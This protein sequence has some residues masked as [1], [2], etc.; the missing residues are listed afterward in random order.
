MTVRP[1][2][3]ERPTEAEGP[4]SPEVL[5]KEAR[6][7]RRRRWAVGVALMVGVVS[8]AAGLAVP[9]NG[10]KQPSRS[11]PSSP[12]GATPGTPNK[13]TPKA[14]AAL[15][16]STPRL[17]AVNFFNPTDGYGLFESGAG[18]SCVPGVAPTKDGGGYFAPLV[19]LPGCGASNVAF[20]D[21]GDGFAYGP[22]L[23]VTHDA[24]TTWSAVAQP[25]VV[26]S[27]EALGA[28]VW[29]LEA[30]CAHPATASTPAQTC[31]PSVAQSANGGRTWATR[32]TQPG[33]GSLRVTDGS[34]SASLVRVS[35]TSAYVVGTPGHTTPVNRPSTTT[36]AIP[37]WFTANG[38]RTWTTESIPCGAPN[39]PP[40]VS[41]RLSAA[42]DGTLFAV[43]GYFTQVGGSQDKAV[44]VSSDHGAS[45]SARGRCFEG[46]S[47]TCPARALESG[48]VG[49]LDAVSATTAFEFGQ[50]GGLLETTDGGTTWIGE[51]STGQAPF[52]TGPAALLFFGPAHGVILG[53]TMVWHTSDGTTWRPV[54]P[55]AART[56][57]ASTAPCTASQLQVSRG[58]SA[59]ADGHVLSRVFLTNRGRTCTLSGFPLLSGISPTGTRRALFTARGVWFGTLLP[60]VL[61][62]GEQGQL[63]LQ[64]TTTCGGATHVR[65]NNM[66]VGLPGAG[67][68]LSLGGLSFTLACGISESQLGIP[69]K[70]SA[71]LGSVASL[72]VQLQPRFVSALPGTV[73]SGS[74]L[75]Y[76]VTLYNLTRVTVRMVPC[77]RYTVIFRTGTATSKHEHVLARYSAA[78]ACRTVGSIP[79][80]G[81]AKVSLSVR[82]PDVSPIT[83]GLLWKFDVPGVVTRPKS[84]STTGVAES[85][86]KIFTA[87]MAAQHGGK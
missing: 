24:G 85:G 16:S 30:I 9:G 38:G 75:H 53:L 2:L 15:A 23:Y 5:F 11:S 69:P 26:L 59:R 14:S 47:A 45:W 33:P 83:A 54:I 80:G 76:T 78:F 51:T 50:R 4:T 64:T 44:F 71:P 62:H 10:G 6:R 81:T 1:P 67:G 52:A 57:A 86:M 22:D 35:T 70:R 74:L 60:A 31:R 56:S 3:L 13:S 66:V 25:G 32:P 41:A 7:R 37:L 58:S 17:L 46:P 27:V 79:P 77:P 39:R 43:C 21:H 73:I 42:P 19:P 84:T 68:T 28:S 55:V 12:Q 34:S 49:T 36:G 61:A 40:P 63:W 18:A 72:K 82:A 20:D 65:V 8:V 87:Q 29:M 48:Y